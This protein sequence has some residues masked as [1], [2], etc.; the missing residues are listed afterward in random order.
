MAGVTLDT[1]VQPGTDADVVERYRA[2]AKRA[3]ETIFGFEDELVFVDVE[4]TGFDPARDAIV[5]VGAVIARGGEILETFGTL[6]D[7]RRALPIEITELTGITDEMLAGAPTIEV[8]ARDLIAFAAGR[9]LVAHNARFDRDFLARVEA[10]AALSACTWYDSLEL[11]RIALPR[12]RS[13]RLTDLAAAF[14]FA[15]G[16]PHRAPDDA[17][18]LARLWRVLLVAASDLAPSILHALATEGEVL[19]PVFAHLATPLPPERLDL[20]ALR[21]RRLRRE[22]VD[23]L[24]DAAEVDIVPV[25]P[26]VVEAA[27]LPEGTVARMYERY[28][29]RT[30]QQAMAEAVREAFACGRHLAVEA[31]TGVGKSVAYLVPA[32]HLA[33]ANGVSVGVATKTNTLMDQLLYRELPALSRELSGD[34]RYVAL[35]GYDHYVCLRKLDRA[36]AAIGE[37]DPEPR[38]TVLALLAWVAQSSWGDLD[39]VNLH[40]TGR[41]RR[42]V[43]ASA[44]ECTKKRCRFYPHLCYLHGQRRRAGRAHVIVTNH[45]LLFADV[46]REGGILPPVRYWVVDEAHAVEDEAREQLSTGASLPSLNAALQALH[47]DGRGGVLDAVRAKAVRERGSWPE[48]TQRLDEM[49]GISTT[50][51]TVVRSLFETVREIASAQSSEYDRVHVRITAAVRRSAAW[52]EVERIARSLATKLDRLLRL[53]GECITLL[54]EGGEAFDEVRADLAGQAMSVSEQLAGLLAVI[55]GEDDRFVYSVEANRRP[56]AG[57]VALKAARL[58]V[59]EDLADRFLA[60]ARSVVFTSATIATGDDFSHF[61]RAVGLDR[62]PDDAHGALRLASSYDFER[63][64]A[65]YV[66]TDIAPPNDWGYLADLERLL[67]DVHLAMGGSVLTLFTNVR[68]ME[69]LYGPVAMAL[70]DAGLR[71]IIQAR[72]VSRKRIVDEFLADERVSLFATKSFWEGFDAKGDTL[73][74]VVIPRLPFAPVND[75]V[76]E[77]R[78]ERDR[79]WWDHYYLPRAIIELKQA[80]GRLIRSATDE[81]C[82]VLA[83]ARLVGSKPYAR[84]FLEALPVREVTC[85]PSAGVISEI[86][87]RFGR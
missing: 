33:L 20:K 54:E 26:A 55:E 29:P 80:A 42:L 14:G 13:H 31:G 36:L 86:A 62:L 49:R 59:G 32:V 45:A 7:P 41:L 83:D 48:L 19:G 69:R 56:E 61:E 57:E 68:D 58:D 73:R 71:L 84:R 82:L 22:R 12:L 1:L 46:V 85:L 52:G 9:P 18:T 28:E 47:A 2:L 81:G 30:E 77:E 15:Q 16:R 74:C 4:T 51:S 66:P 40:W 21:Q 27:F 11:A 72:G 53:A 79:A 75:P 44:H 3:K 43:A 78:R 5:E 35:K 64:M 34:V 6:V 63:Q 23:E 39:T 50:A 70:R 87:R 65:V 60:R 17:L 10:G 38:L 25:D 24:P 76:L 8:V 67:I 37:L